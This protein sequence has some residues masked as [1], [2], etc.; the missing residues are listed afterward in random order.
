MTISAQLKVE[1]DYKTTG[2]DLYQIQSDIRTFIHDHPE[3]VRQSQVAKHVLR[4]PPEIDHNWITHYV[5]LEM[6]NDG[7]IIRNDKQLFFLA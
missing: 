1:K 4:I 2:F 6:I 7:Q 5:L 3:G